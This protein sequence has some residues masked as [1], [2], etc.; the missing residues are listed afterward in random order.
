MKSLVF[1]LWSGLKDTSVYQAG[2]PFRALL[3]NTKG[4]ARRHSSRRSKPPLDWFRPATTYVGDAGSSWNPGR[5][6]SSKTSHFP[7]DLDRGPQ[8]RSPCGKTPDR[9]SHT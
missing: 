4:M 8:F 9:Y 1:R 6:R 3:T 2:E 5:A 7:V